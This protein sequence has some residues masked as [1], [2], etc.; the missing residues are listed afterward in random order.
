MEQQAL[1]LLTKVYVSF[2]P[3]SSPYSDLL[4]GI[5]IQTRSLLKAPLIKCLTTAPLLMLP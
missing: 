3:Y 1:L 2:I 4:A 5:E